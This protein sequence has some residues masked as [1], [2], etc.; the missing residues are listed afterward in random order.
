M[1]IYERKS[2]WKLYLGIIGGVIVLVTMLYS[3]YLAN[4]L[5]AFER[6]R[7]ELY[8]EALKSVT[9]T[10][11]NDQDDQNVEIFILQKIEGI[12]VVLEDEEGNLIGE[13]YDRE[14]T[15]KFLEREKQQFLDSGKKPIE[16]RGYSRYIYYRNSKL[17]TYIKLFPIV[18]FFMLGAFILL[19]Y[20]GF[21]SSRKAEQNR[22]WAGMA[23]ETA[24]QLG[25]PISA[26]IGWI[27]HL[28][29]DDQ[30]TPDQMEIVQELRSDVGRLE[31]IADRFSKIGSKPKLDPA[32]IV[33]VIHK[34]IAYMK[35]RAPRR[36]EFNVVAD[37]DPINASINH[38]LFE[39]VVE[40]LLRN[41][42][43]AMDGQ[44]KIEAN[45]YRLENSIYIDISDTGKGIPSN[46]MKTVFQPGFSTKKRGWGLGLSLAK[47]IIEEYHQGKIFVK[48]SKINEGTTFTIQ[49][50]AST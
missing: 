23:K 47:R 8:A 39:W 2:K 44:G 34:S 45:V 48:S 36:M 12:P 30:M 14:V 28:K 26:I 27:E 13:N 38:H 15:A 21:S 24:H 16:S 9:K 17:L 29:L 40:N 18:Q 6:S 19:G 35:K 7:V 1:D 41:S 49:L 33:D 31:L 46:K 22:V 3:R 11:Y 42:L 32:N 43:D 10:D 4:Q 25:T 50:P 37:Q 5:E 20:L